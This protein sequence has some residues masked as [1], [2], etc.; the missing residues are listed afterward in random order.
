[1]PFTAALSAHPV[2]AHAVGEVI[3]QVLEAMDS[4]PPDLAI[5]F[6]SGHHRAAAADA[7]V[8]LGELL[9][10]GALLGATAS[11]VM[12]NGREVEYAPALTLWAG[13]F[14]AVQTFSFGRDASVVAPPFEPRLVLLLV[15][16]FG[17]RAESALAALSTRWPDVPIVGGMASAGG[18]PGANRLILDGSISTS[19]AV[20]VLLGPGVE[21]EAVV[22]SGARPIGPPYAVTSARGRVVRG[23]GGQSPL[24]RLYQ[25]LD[26]DAGDG[27]GAG[28]RAG[29][30]GGLCLG[31]VVDEG[32]FQPAPGDLLVSDILAAGPDGLTIDGEVEVGQTWQFLVRDAEAADDDLRAALNGRRADTALAFPDATRS[33]DLFPDESH[34][35]GVLAEY[36]ANPPTAGMSCAGE[37]GPVGGRNLPLRSAVSIALLREIPD[38]RPVAG[39]ARAPRV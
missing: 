12:A 27:A 9:R 4:R 13:R 31:R 10:P 26:Q 24:Q 37:I 28:S 5:C 38:G 2:A 1:M 8:T 17:F 39:E 34:D 18:G 11:A 22:S 15:D 32:A 6:L 7:A 14:G 16:P 35:A 23:L 25:I 21:I 30:W 29:G 33:L 3:G 36:L 20:G 19:G